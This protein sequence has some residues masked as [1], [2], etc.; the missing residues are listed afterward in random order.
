MAAPLH[1]D[2]E[3]VIRAADAG[4]MQAQLMELGARNTW[5]RPGH[6]FPNGSLPKRRNEFDAISATDVTEILAVT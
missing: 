1:V 2:D 4:H 6:P 3:P 5:L